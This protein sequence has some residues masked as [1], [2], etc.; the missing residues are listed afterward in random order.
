MGSLGAEREPFSPRSSPGEFGV[1]GLR[2]GRPQGVTGLDPTSFLPKWLRGFLVWGGGA[3][4]DAL[5]QVG[6]SSR[7][8]LWHFHVCL[9]EQG[10]GGTGCLG[11]GQ[12][13]PAGARGLVRPCG[14]GP[15]LPRNCFCPKL[16]RA[17][18]PPPALMLCHLRAPLLPGD[19][20][21]ARTVSPSSRLFPCPGVSGAQAGGEGKNSLRIFC[22]VFVVI[23][24]APE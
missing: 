20:S 4:V 13:R 8:W 7:S 15:G 2:E 11:W 14:R 22:K 19:T 3:A 23:F 9:P 21:M 5:C 17:L 18:Q 6:R 10:T 12:E 1:G 24:M 16:P